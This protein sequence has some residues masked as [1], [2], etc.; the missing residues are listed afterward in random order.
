MNATDIIEYYKL[1]SKTADYAKSL[2]Y[3]VAKI[4]YSNRGIG[5][6]ALKEFEELDLYVV[7][8][9]IERR[10]SITSG[11]LNQFF[12][13]IFIE[14]S[15]Q[16]FRYLLLLTLRRNQPQIFFHIQFDHKIII[17]LIQSPKPTWENDISEILDAPEITVEEYEKQY[18][19]KSIQRFDGFIIPSKNESESIAQAWLPTLEGEKLLEFMT[20]LFPIRE[21]KHK[22]YIAEDNERMWFYIFTWMLWY[23]FRYMVAAVY[24]QVEEREIEDLHKLLQGK[25]IDSRVGECFREAL[26]VSDEEYLEVLETIKGYYQKQIAKKRYRYL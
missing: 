18:Y 23:K 24:E 21:L 26:E 20:Y 15:R 7:F 16:I 19:Q 10:Y 12:L 25:R 5:F 1:S 13:D 22:K 11:I 4:S 9:E 6:V 2:N 17:F 3:E 14:R 8:P